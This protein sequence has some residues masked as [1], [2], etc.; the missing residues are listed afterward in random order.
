M[1]Q[2]QPFISE[3]EVFEALEKIHRG[4][5]GHHPGS[6]RAPPACRSHFVDVT[7]GLGALRRATRSA[8]AQHACLQ[9][10]WEARHCQPLPCHVLT[11]ARAPCLQLGRGGTAAVNYESDIVP[12][13]MRKTIAGVTPVSPRSSACCARLLPCS[14]PAAAAL[15]LVR[16]PPYKALSAGLP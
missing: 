1:R 9:L 8:A 7:L 10:A 14:C 13:S 16:P 3:A 15:L 4:K 12:P 5:V 6:V 11:L 2:Q